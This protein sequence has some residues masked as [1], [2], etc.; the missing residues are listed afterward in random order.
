LVASNP[1]PNAKGESEIENDDEEVG[2]MQ[3][4]PARSWRR[5]SKK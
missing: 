1:E 4:R 2:C 5:G 3:M